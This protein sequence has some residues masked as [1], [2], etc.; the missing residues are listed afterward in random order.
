MYRA[1]TVT[2]T[3]SGTVRIAVE[4]PAPRLV[5]APL[6]PGVAVPLPDSGYSFRVTADNPGAS[7]FVEAANRPAAGAGEIVAA[8]ETAGEPALLELFG[9]AP[10]EPYATFL[11]LWRQQAET[12]LRLAAAAT[13]LA[14][15]TEERRI[16]GA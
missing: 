7:W 8:L 11:A 13:A 12:P 6:V 15:R 10:A 3:G 9:A 1:Y 4:Q 14:Y 2:P 5:I 16:A